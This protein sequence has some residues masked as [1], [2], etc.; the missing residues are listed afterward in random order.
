MSSMGASYAA[1][2]VQQKR[3][4][5]RLMKKLEEVEK[6]RK[7]IVEA[8]AA[9]PSQSHRKSDKICTAAADNKI[10]PAPIL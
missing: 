10:H 8:A 6:S 4:K 9:S 5:E 2:Y 7:F 3:Q 1:I